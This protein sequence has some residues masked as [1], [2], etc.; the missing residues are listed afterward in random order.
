MSKMDASQTLDLMENLGRQR[1]SRNRDIVEDGGEP[2]D[3]LVDND[4]AIHDPWLSSCGRFEVDPYIT[5]GKLFFE[6]LMRPFYSDG[7]NIVRRLNENMVRQIH[8]PDLGSISDL[9][10]GFVGSH[11]RD[12]G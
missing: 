2:E 8:N 7:A 6:W 1:A 11:L 4:V 10:G 9:E 12:R 5:Y 3:Y